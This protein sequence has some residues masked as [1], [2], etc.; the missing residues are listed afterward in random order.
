MA[1]AGP[2]NPSTVAASHDP[3]APM[4]C[5]RRRDA[6]DDVIGLESLE[7]LASNFLQKTLAESLDTKLYLWYQS[8][9]KNAFG[10]RLF[11][12]CA[13]LGGV[14]VFVWPTLNS[15]ASKHSNHLVIRDSNGTSLRSLFEGLSPSSARSKGHWVRSRLPGGSRKCAGLAASLGIELTVFAQDNWCVDNQGICFGCPTVNDP[16]G[17]SLDY[18]TCEGMCLGGLSGWT[19][20]LTDPSSNRGAAFTGQ[21]S[22][23]GTNGCACKL[24]YCSDCGGS[25]Q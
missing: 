14:A 16:E 25:G 13:V 3:A 18:G 17:I 6:R 8:L 22:C 7:R 1:C 4:A 19:V 15:P 20:A 9:V 2:S 10:A 24:T 23:N 11:T 12:A 21:T 5:L